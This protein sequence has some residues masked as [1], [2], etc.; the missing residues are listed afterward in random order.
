MPDLQISFE[1]GESSLVVQRFLVEE[2]LSTAFAIS[3]WAH[4]GNPALELDALVGRR[5]SFHLSH[6][7]SGALAAEGRTWS[8][9]CAHAEQVRVEPIGVSTYFFRLV[10]TLWSLGM[11]RNHRIFQHLA[12]P[13]LVDRLL[14]EWGIEREWEVVRDDYPKLEYKVQYGETD[15]AFLLRVLEEAGIAFAFVERDGASKLLLADALQARD[16]RPGAPLPCVDNPNQIAGEEFVTQLHVAREVRPGG[17]V[18]RDHDPRRPAFALFGKAPP[19]EGAEARLEQYHYQP[20]GFL[21]EIGSGGDTPVADD[22]GVARHDQPFG[23][24]RAA[25]ALEGERALARVLSFETNALD[26]APSTVFVADVGGEERLLMTAARIEGTRLGDWRISGRAVSAGAPWRPALRT[27]KPRIRGIQSA[28]VVGAS[29]DEIHADELGRVRVQF[30]WD[31]EG[32][33]DE[34]SSCWIRSGE[35]W[36]GAGYGWLTLPRVGQE[37]LVSFL[38]GDPDQPILVGRVFNAAQPVPYKLPESKTIST[39]KSDSSPGSQGFNEI[40]FEDKKGG[41]LV[42][43][44]A[45]H[46]LRKR[47]KRDETI[48]VGND[49]RKRVGVNEIETV[50]VNRTQVTGVMRIE[51]TGSDRTTLDRKN[52]IERVEASTSQWTEHDRRRKVDKDQDIVVMGKKRERIEMDTHLHVRGD[53]RESIDGKQSRT[54]VEDVH[55]RVEG[56]HALQSGKAL[57][58]AAGETIAVEG[59]GSVT[60]KGPGG[61]IR[62]D[63]SGITIEGTLVKINVGGSPGWAPPSRPDLPEDAKE[64]PVGVPDPQALEE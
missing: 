25:S 6:E 23:D 51:I 44:Q 10:P 49:R 34:T 20:G 27:P 45:E 18:V 40:L 21:A 37:V 53:R 33:R 22:R 61:F 24:R 8:G 4:S 50:G 60:L 16:V 47:V 54:V 46:N 26:L 28:T 30:P 29:K 64:S 59:E 3:V 56:T 39:W 36:A 31:R 63:G 9:L 42:Y 57:H 11:R 7:A 2:A 1:S 15:Y 41:E 17:Y 38:D 52:R 55:E 13:D 58:L 19:A 35:G 32:E 12:A 43:V 5:A 48:T 14:D 62:F